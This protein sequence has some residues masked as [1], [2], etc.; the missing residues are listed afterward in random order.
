[1]NGR[2]C[3]R[4]GYATDETVLLESQGTYPLQVMR[5]HALPSGGGLSLVVLLL[6][7]GL[8]DGDEVSIEGTSSR[9]RGSRC[10]PSGDPD[11]AGRSGQILTARV[12]ERAWFSYLPPRWCPCHAI[13]RAPRAQRLGQQAPARPS[14]A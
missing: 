8:L 6:S 9:A 3:L 14:G 11:H 10:V 2:L 5:P 13:P 7:G 4:A 1:L 12:G